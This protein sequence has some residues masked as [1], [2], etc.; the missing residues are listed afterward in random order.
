M[1]RQQMYYVRICEVCRTVYNCKLPVDCTVR[2]SDPS[3]YFTRPARRWFEARNNCTFENADLAVFDSHHRLQLPILKAD[4]IYYIGLRKVQLRWNAPGKDSD[5][6][7]FYTSQTKSESHLRGPTLHRT[8][9]CL[10]L[11]KLCFIQISTMV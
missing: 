11:F 5:Q 7:A 3:C 9:L 4:V 8:R 1:T 2:S 10:F 6:F